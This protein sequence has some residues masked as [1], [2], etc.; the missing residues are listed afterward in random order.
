MNY[1]GA[2][3]KADKLCKSVGLDELIDGK[4]PRVIAIQHEDGSYLEFR[5]AFFRKLD[6][7]WMVVIT[8]HHGV[9]VYHF[10]DVRWI[11]EKKWNK[12]VELYRQEKES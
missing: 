3:E 5:S 7:E 9:F 11:K 6:D 8:E 10:E 2:Q 1:K 12:L 4:S